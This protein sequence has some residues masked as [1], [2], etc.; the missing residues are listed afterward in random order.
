MRVGGVIVMML[1]AGRASA[2]S[3]SP[4]S[5]P[6]HHGVTVEAGLA[7][8]VAGGVY[9]IAPPVA[10]V[11][12]AGVGG[13][14]T[15]H[16][17]LTGRAFGSV[18]SNEDNRWYIVFV[19]PTLQYWINRRLW[20]GY[21]AGFGELAERE[22]VG[23]K[24]HDDHRGVALDLRVGTAFELAPRQTFYVSLELSSWHLALA[25]STCDA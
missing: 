16:T 7:A 23:A 12:S 1:V 13:W 10:P 2:Q 8:D 18:S 6:V 20:I 14:L 17:A 19:G 11:V 25:I 3:S 4:P 22:L 5:E 15:E 9:T 21:G 24:S